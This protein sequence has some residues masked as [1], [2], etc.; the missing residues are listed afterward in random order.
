MPPEI[1]ITRSFDE[2]VDK[3]NDDKNRNKLYAA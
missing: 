3:Q 2:R 1:S